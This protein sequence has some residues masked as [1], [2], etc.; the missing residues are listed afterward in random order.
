[1]TAEAGAFACP[2]AIRD[3]WW[4]A[5]PTGACWYSVPR[6]IAG[7]A[8]LADELRG[9]AAGTPVVLCDRWP[10]SRSRTR[11]LLSQAGIRLAREYV[12]LPTL[13]SAGVLVEDDDATASYVAVRFGSAPPAASWRGRLLV[14][15]APLGRRMLAGRWRGVAFGGRVVIGL[16]P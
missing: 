15:L 16:R 3:K 7:R 1:M 2:Q 12:A 8:R 11:A 4:P 5:L 13:S 14:R 6:T 10:H 9:L